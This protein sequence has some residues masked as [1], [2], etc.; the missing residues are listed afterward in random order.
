MAFDD[1]ASVIALLSLLKEK[2]ILTTEE[3]T[4]IKRHGKVVP[5]LI[6]RGILTREEYDERSEMVHEIIGMATGLLKKGPPY[7]STV[8]KVLESYKKHFPR[9]VEELFGVMEV[10]GEG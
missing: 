7:S 9:L 4:E 1:M 3:V 6:Q 2:K 5:I 8:I 10:E